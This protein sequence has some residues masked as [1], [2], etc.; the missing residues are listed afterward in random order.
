MSYFYNKHITFQ[1]NFMAVKQYL[2]LSS[3]K[4]CKIGIKLC[5]GK[6]LSINVFKL[7]F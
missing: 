5:I 1:L 6:Y 4:K 7:N 2:S 3:A